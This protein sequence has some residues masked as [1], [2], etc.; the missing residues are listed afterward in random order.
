M[1]FG[2]GVFFYNDMEASA[3]MVGS[4][5]TLGDRSHGTIMKNVQ[6]LL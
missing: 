1:P 5:R 3:D 4:V 6:V 2:R